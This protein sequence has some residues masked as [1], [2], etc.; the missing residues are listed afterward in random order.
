MDLKAEA[1]GTIAATRKFFDRT[2]RCLDESDSTFRP[3]PATMT[4][5]S[6]VAHAAQVIDWFRAGA[7]ENDWNMDFAAQQAETDRVTSLA[8]AR[9][10]L[11][12]AWARLVERLER[13]S[14]AELAAAMHDNPILQTLPRVHVVAA[15][16]DHA[17]HHRGALA[18][19]ARL[20]G[21]SPEMPYGDD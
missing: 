4:V 9:A 2:T 3:H 21:R 6:Q 16:V 11:D 20:A 15:I 17:A 14:E 1:L 7:F 13:A 19:Y 8:T 18:V 12:A 10:W 5:A